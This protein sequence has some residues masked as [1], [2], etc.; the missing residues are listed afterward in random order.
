MIFPLESLVDDQS[1]RVIKGRVTISNPA[2][3]IGHLAYHAMMLE[4]S[5]H[6]KPGLVTSLSSGAHCDM[7]IA[8]FE[9]SAQALLP[10]MIRFAEQGYC[11]S[12]QQM[13]KK[14]FGSNKVD[15]TVLLASIRPLGLAAEQ[16]MFSATKGVNTHKG[17]IFILGIVCAA[18]GYLMKRRGMITP[19][20]IQQTTKS[21]CAGITRELSQGN[22]TTNGEKVFKKHGI[23]GVRGEAEQGFPTLIAGLDVYHSAIASGRSNDHAMQ[24]AL[25]RCMAT[26][27]DSCLVKRGGLTGLD[28]ARNNAS[29]LLSQPF[30]PVQ[31]RHQLTALDT[32]FINRN[33]SPGGSAD[34]LSAIWL[35]SQI[36]LLT[37][38]E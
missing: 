14:T 10:H 30:N 26:N 7:D 22:A 20:L 34:F 11:F 1:L 17:A 3:L 5:L 9:A 23:Y 16:S 28:F 27:M 33:L 12:E 32:E 31:L 15:L 18:M 29:K 19:S 25:L 38:A 24:L 35:I 6:P 2:R 4:V 37:Q 36:E 8:T 13:Q 21:M